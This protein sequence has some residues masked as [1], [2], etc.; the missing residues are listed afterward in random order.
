MYQSNFFVGMKDILQKSKTILLFFALVLSNSLY[1]QFMQGFSFTTYTKKD[2]LAF[3]QVNCSY[4]DSEGFLWVGTRH[5][6]SCYDGYRFQNYFHDHKDQSSLSGNDI[7]WVEEDINGDIWIATWGGGVSV[8]NKKTKKFTRYTNQSEEIKLPGDG[9]VRLLHCDDKGK[10]WIATNSEGILCFDIKKQEMKAMPSYGEKSIC[11]LTTIED[12]RLLVGSWNTMLDYQILEDTLKD[13]KTYVINHPRAVLDMSEDELLIGAN[14]GLYRFNYT[15]QQLEQIIK[16]KDVV[17]LA[18][19]KEGVL[20][21]T[22]AGLA[23]YQQHSN[24]LQ[25]INKELSITHLFHDKKEDIFWLSTSFGLVRCERRPSV[26]KQH[27]LNEKFI[28]IL[29]LN[30][31][32]FLSITNHSLIIHDQEQILETL[33]TFPT[34]YFAHL[35]KL[36]ERYY[37]FTKEEELFLV[38]IQ[39]KS[40]ER[41]KYP[42]FVKYLFYDAN[43]GKIYLTTSIAVIEY[44]LEIEGFRLTDEKE[45]SIGEYTRNKIELYI[46]NIQQDAQ[47]NLWIGMYN[48]GLLK[49]NMQEQTVKMALGT[50]N[51]FIENISYDDANQKIW[52]SSREGLMYMDLST[53]TPTTSDYLIKNNWLTLIEQDDNILWLG[54]YDGIIRYDISSSQYNLF[55]DESIMKKLISHKS[56]KTQDRIYALFTRKGFA[57][58]DRKLTKQKKKQVHP[59]VNVLATPRQKFLSFDQELILPHNENNISISF[60]CIDFQYQDEHIFQTRISKDKAWVDHFASSP[61]V[62]NYGDITPGEYEFQLRL[63]D[64]EEITS[65][66]F[67]VLPPFWKSNYA[68]L[69]YSIIVLGTLLLAY[70]SMKKRERRKNQLKE[71]LIRVEEE[72]KYSKLRWRL[73]TDISHEIKTPLTL[74]ISP[75]EEFVRGKKEQKLDLGTAQLVLRNAER[76]EELVK[77]LLD[78]RKVESNMLKL[79]I[80]QEDVVMNIRIIKESFQSLANQYEFDFQFHTDTESYQGYFDKDILERIIINLLSNAFKYTPPQG[81]ISIGL[82]V[83]E[84][85]E[86][87]L[88]NVSDTGVGIDE[89]TQKGLFERFHGKGDVQSEKFSST[90]LGL[91][92]VKELIRFHHATIDFES[93]PKEGTVFKLNIPLS[94]VFYEE[95]NAQ[96]VKEEEQA[97]EQT[98]RKEETTEE[99]LTILL[100][101]DNQDIHHYLKNELGK[102]Y[103]IVPFTNGYDASMQVEKVMPDLVLSDIMMPRM[104]GIE[105]CQKIKSSEKTSH[106]PVILLTAKG[107][108]DNKIEGLE[109]GADDYIKKP[110]RLEEVKVRIKNVILTRQKLQSKFS[111]EVILEGKTIHSD[112]LDEQFIKK[113]M[114]V[115][116]KHIEN[117]KFDNQLFCQEIGYGKTQLYTKIKALTDMSPN[118]FIRVIRLKRAAVLIKQRAA[119]ISEVAYMVGFSSAKYFSTCFKELFGKSPR[120]YQNDEDSANE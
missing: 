31:D 90:G 33:F 51:L 66:A 58:I 23:L 105:L 92:L 32:T 97:P 42:H 8:F 93:Q 118:E 61:R 110:F 120:Q 63:K 75:L 98:E 7:S 101:E 49:L 43:R 57:S 85:E 14:E 35:I 71:Q 77:Q 80:Q 26:I 70:W 47:G 16:T 60:S 27:L 12:N 41:K 96:F 78:F 86:Q 72:K 117:P 34:A 107:S 84:A 4:R 19:E 82:Q 17:G 79:N 91:S 89:D 53:P 54:S 36:S 68:Y 5:G 25:W 115:V 99:K 2:G 62:V 50:E 83:N 39:T 108:H 74:I 67:T 44:T 9:I 45:I 37:M 119:N 3:N 103:T 87:I 21:A 113:A 116:E 11:S 38:D 69:L 56:F 1:A 102:H 29:P 24:A 10:V 81:K 106:I 104:T 114:E 94:K 55:Q 22:T 76:L 109:S 112:S 20:L 52:I 40:I 30:D 48:A 95:R 18:K 28:N 100:A 6:L 65:L 46:R 13:N 88:I 73:F 15:S 64:S 59:F 111:K